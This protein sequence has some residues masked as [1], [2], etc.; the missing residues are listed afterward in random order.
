MTVRAVAVLS[1]P[2][3]GSGHRVWV[4]DL[5]HRAALEC[6]LV[7]RRSQIAVLIFEPERIAKKENDAVQT[8]PAHSRL[9]IV[10]A[11]SII[12]RELFGIGRI[13]RKHVVKGHR[14]PTL[15]GRIATWCV[16]GTERRA[17]CFSI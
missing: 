4:S 2:V 3:V 14:G 17:M 12:V 16:I 9:V 13:A 1:R 11:E 10:V 7:V 8:G 6:H 5:V 15:T